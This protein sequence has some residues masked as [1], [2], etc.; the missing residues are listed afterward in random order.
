MR[1]LTV[2]CVRCSFLDASIKLPYAAMAKKVRACSISTC[3]A[4]L[5]IVYF[6]IVYKLI[7]FDLYSF[8][9]VILLKE[10]F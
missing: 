2:D 1:A 9:T 5:C 8:A 7:S 3:L 10:I 6:D 4:T